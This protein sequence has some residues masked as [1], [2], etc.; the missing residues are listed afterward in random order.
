MAKHFAVIAI[1]NK[2]K[3]VI[4]EWARTIKAVRLKLRLSQ[5]ELAEKLETSAMAISRWERGEFTPSADVYLRLGKL[6]GDRLCWFFWGRAGLSTAD[7][8]RV[9]PK[10]G[11]RLREDR[12]AN[13][14]VVHAGA[15]RR[16]SKKETF[17]AVPLLPVHAAP[18]GEE[19]DKVAD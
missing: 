17:V 11:L 4:P 3:T 6:M 8:M 1:R 10:A 14:Q 18:P 19:G 2:T 5:S 13:V 15:K 12:S 7:V 9:L 16:A